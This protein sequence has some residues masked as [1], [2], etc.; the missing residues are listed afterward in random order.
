MRRKGVLVENGECIGTK[1]IVVNLRR[2]GYALRGADSQEMAM[3]ISGCSEATV[4]WKAKEV[5]RSHGFVLFL[6]G[7]DGYE[8]FLPEACPVEFGGLA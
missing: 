2:G 6:E 5:A 7:D 1:V 8:Y 3:L 4:L